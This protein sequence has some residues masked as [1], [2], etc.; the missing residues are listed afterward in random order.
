ML[1][2]ATTIDEGARFKIWLQQ[3][4]FDLKAANSSK[5]SG[6]YEWACFQ[7]EQAV[8]KGLKAIL[9]NAGWR[10]PKMH[11]LAVLIHY[12]NDANRKFRET[13]FEFRDLEASTFVSRYPFLIPGENL[14]PHE[15]ITLENAT[16]CIEQAS[17]M[18]QKIRQ[19]LQ[20]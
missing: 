12:C 6:F 1:R 13:K 14:S 8:E 10:P 2:K 18:L 7:S 20:E 16:K 4:D 5:D 9:V 19:L 15:F 11:K 17:S 3:A